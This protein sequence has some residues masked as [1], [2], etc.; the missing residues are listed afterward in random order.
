MIYLSVII[1]AYN[2]AQRIG[3]TLN[4]TFDYLDA[5][6]YASEVIVVD[7]GSNDQ[8]MQVVDEFEPRAVGRL[9]VVRNP[10]NRGKGYAVR[11]GMLR[12]QG[13]ISLFFDADMSTPPSEIAKIIEPIAKGDYDIVFG[14]RALAHELI[15]ARQSLLRELS[16]R[17]FNLIM[18]ALVG[19]RFKDTQCGFKAFRRQT[20]QS[21]FAI[22][23]IEGFG[24][25]P[26]VL[27]IAQKQ[28][29]NLLEL[30]VCWNHVEGSKVR[31]LSTPFKMLFE[32]L[33][34]RW[35]NLN[36]KYDKSQVN[37]Q[38]L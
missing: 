14:S 28:G 37:S 3:R 1:P 31:L 29:W 24:F 2:E 25:D 35:N 8:T 15:G 30:P 4:K 11:N 13:E 18:R 21:V 20:A 27:F 12:A 17:A 26:E 32:L 9:Q 16:G 22:Q 33:T 5:Q 34:I 38:I 36:G 7:D 6:N 10:G 19:L 23:R